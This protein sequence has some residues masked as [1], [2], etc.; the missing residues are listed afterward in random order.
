MF[1]IDLYR[2]DWNFNLCNFLI[3]TK[4]HLVEGMICNSCSEIFRNC[5]KYEYVFNQSS[6]Q[7]PRSMLAHI[8]L[9]TRK[10]AEKS[11]STFPSM[12]MSF[13]YSRDI[14]LYFLPDSDSVL[15][16]AGM[17]TW[18]QRS[19]PSPPSPLLTTTWHRLWKRKASKN[20]RHLCRCWHRD[21]RCQPNKRKMEV[22]YYNLELLPLPW[23]ET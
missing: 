10:I 3:S 22:L 12:E 9:R 14:S 8:A 6:L 15:F 1:Y 20:W 21:L 16:L 7:I 19:S 17:Q 11:R 13:R 2:T 4:Y 5:Q 18:T 23:R